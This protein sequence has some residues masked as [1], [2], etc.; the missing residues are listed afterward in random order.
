MK[1]I[2]CEH[3]G[4]VLDQDKIPFPEDSYLEEDDSTKI[5]YNQ[6]SRRWEIY[7]PCPVCKEKIFKE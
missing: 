5:D 4:V 7:V 3:C 1:L 2:S 6:R